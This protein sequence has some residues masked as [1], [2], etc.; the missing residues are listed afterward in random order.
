M[1]TGRCVCGQVTFQSE[2]PWRD[3]I[4]CHCEECRRTS[5]HFWAATAVPTDKLELTNDAGLKWFRATDSATRGFCTGCGASL[6]FR[7]D[8]RDY[9]AIAAGAVDQPSGLKMVEEVFTH[10]KGDYYDLSD[11]IT[12]SGGFSKAWSAENDYKWR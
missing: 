3:I 4:S 11:G 12:H 8:G 7:M 6:F 10:E 5:G 2:G 9:T 1:K